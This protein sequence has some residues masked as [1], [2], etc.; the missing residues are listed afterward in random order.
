[1]K[2]F[3]EAI[4]SSI[5]KRRY[6][7]LVIILG[8]TA[9]FAYNI[10][11]FKLVNDPDT[12]SP[13]EHPNMIFNRWAEK[14][15]GMGNVAIIAIKL[16]K[17]GKFKSV[18]NAV[19]LKKLWDL[20]KAYEELPH[21][22]KSNFMSLA[23]KKMRHVKGEN[24]WLKVTLMM[25]DPET[26][27]MEEQVEHIKE[28]VK[29]NKLY[30]NFLASDDETTLFIYLDFHDSVKA[31]YLDTWHKIYGLAQKIVTDDD[32]EVLFGGEVPACSWM[33]DQV[34]KNGPLIIPCFAIIF[35]ILWLEFGSPV[36]A[37]TPFLGASFSF[38]WT[39]GFMGV[40]GFALSSTAPAILLLVLAVGLNHCMQL[41]R[42]FCEQL[43]MGK[44]REKA[45]L[46]VILLLAPASLSSISAGVIGFALLALFPVLIYFEYSIFGSFGMFSYLIVCYIFV[47][48]CLSII[49]SEKQIAKISERENREG[50]FDS[51]ASFMSN[52]V[53]GNG[54]WAI[55]AGTV[56][57]VIACFMLIPHMIVGANLTK[58]AAKPDS[59]YIRWDEEIRKTIGAIPFSMC[60]ESKEG[61]KDTLKN[62]EIL[63]AMSQLEEWFRKEPYGTYVISIA[64]FLKNLNY[65]IWEMEQDKYCIPDTKGQ[66]ADLFFGYRCGGDP[67]DFDS[68]IS[69][70]NE[71]GLIL[72]F[73]NE[74]DP[75]I[76]SDFRTRFEAKIY[77]LFSP[78]MDKY[79]INV[80]YTGSFMGTILSLDDITHEHKW[81]FWM[82]FILAIFITM[83]VILRSIVASV[84]ILVA[85]LL[86]VLFQ[87][88]WMGL[89]SISDN[90]L[91]KWTGDLNFSSLMMFGMV[92]GVG[93]D[94]SIYITQRLRQEYTAAGGNIKE[95]LR[96]TY[97]STG[98]AVFLTVSAFCLVLVPLMLTPLANLF[99][100]SLILIPDF[101]VAFLGSVFF[102]P[103]VF[104]IFKPRALWLKGV[105][106]EVKHKQDSEDQ[107]LAHTEIQD[108]WSY[109]N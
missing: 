65:H 79:G 80:R 7:V 86:C 73:Y 49:I 12:F 44:S 1:M 69:L 24:G 32:H 83:A 55:I 104:V 92:I 38:I 87:Y 48:V 106:N 99:A 78:L 13:P 64:D 67:S 3:V 72:G 94:Y 39:L 98:R 19:T 47:P 89:C 59:E 95:A 71:K 74:G 56:A 66:V 88:G 31:D 46:Q 81:T 45:A 63:N 20:V 52:F 97:A 61:K 22:W 85:L 77:E 26:Y 9:F 10:R 105:S 102:V 53:M 17:E 5:I 70:N 91:F 54:K 6:L 15:F 4:A 51:M 107:I 50:I 36:V 27:S 18:Y 29:D 8:L 40:S 62:P 11:Y 37:V 23:T 93:V 42:C 82:P 57:F 2:R 101:I 108:S 41:T 25:K 58:L 75:R 33:I 60:I 14:N 84:I 76:L 34:Y 16:K 28:G 35:I 21:A 103:A 68:V 90:P 30:Q 109:N 100:T 96:I 43:S